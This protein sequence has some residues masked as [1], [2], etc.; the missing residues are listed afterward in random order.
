MI[1][2]GAA[3]AYRSPE[4][5]KLATSGADLP[6]RINAARIVKLD[7]RAETHVS[8]AKFLST[9]DMKYVDNFTQ[10]GF[11]LAATAGPATLQAEYQKTSINRMKT[12]NAVVAD[13]SFDGY[14][15]Q[16]SV[17][18]TGERRPYL[19][20][21]GEFGRLIPKRKAG[22][23]ELAARYSMLNLDDVTTVDPIKGGQAKNF[24]LGL[25]WYFNTNHRIMVNFT[26]VDNN[27]NAKPGKDWAP[28]PAGTSTA[29]NVVYGDDF[30]TFSIRY[31]I[32]F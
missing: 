15:A 14:Y 23:L 20:S 31:Q 30:K 27:A 9:G 18:L 12:T 2:F 8:R 3:V 13:H 28:I 6:D 25:N 29:Q 21:E 26:N 10:L 19:A 22:A 11:E 32:A 5:Q 4:R 7:S 24:T 1:H 16:A 17:F